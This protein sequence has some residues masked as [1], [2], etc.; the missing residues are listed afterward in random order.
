MTWL[1]D[2]GI[3]LRLVNSGD[4]LH[5]EVTTACRI[6]KNRGDEFATTAQNIAEFWNVRSCP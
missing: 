3:L 5:N 6:L 4:P 1:L 2:T